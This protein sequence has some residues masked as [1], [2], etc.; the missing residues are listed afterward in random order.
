[1][2]IKISIIIPVY[3]VEEYI[4]ECLLSVANQTMTDGLE[5]IIVDDCGNDDSAIIAKKF[6]D[7]YHGNVQFSFIQRA[8]NGGLSA[9]RNTGI[10][11]ARGEYIYFLDSD[12]YIIPSAIEKLVTI[13]DNCGGVDLLPALFI[14]CQG[15]F[16]E[17]FGRHSFPA[18]SENPHIIKRALLDYYR[19][20]LTATNRL[21]RR[22]LVIDNN[23]W[24]KEGI[25]HEDNYWNFFIAKY[26]K[27]MAFCS[28]K[29]YYYRM[30]QNSIT[31]SVNKE[32]K[33]FSYATMVHDF[34]GNIDNFEVGAQK[35]YI[36]L[37][38][39]TTR[40][41]KEYIP[42]NKYQTLI[43]NFASKCAFSEK[44]LFAISMY[45]RGPIRKLGINL[46]LKLFIN[47]E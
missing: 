1:M 15:H 42:K 24:F 47:S 28:D 35:Q 2:K 37:H 32:K 11:A 45:S 30:N 19:I 23:L 13:T 7:S 22:L 25:I 27:R 34:M 29:L 26:V 12:D 21:I 46:L 14:T 44:I 6:I 33:S 18:F 31:K 43:R 5:C 41:L 17:S 3:N 16:M 8:A 9:A 10:K 40:W 20:P 38:L 4:E 36:F 39:L